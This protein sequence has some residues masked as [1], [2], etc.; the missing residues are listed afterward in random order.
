MVTTDK[1]VFFL[2][3]T[4]ASEENKDMWGL[5]LLGKV[6]DDVRNRIQTETYNGKGI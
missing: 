3:E 1:Y 6:L 2:Y 4:E 5:N